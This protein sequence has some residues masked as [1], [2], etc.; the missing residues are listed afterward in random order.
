MLEKYSPE[1]TILKL[2]KIHMLED[3][4]GNLSEPERT[5]RQR[6]ILEALEGISW[7]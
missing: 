3:Q 2:E 5:K 1:R 7:W 6:D 4:E